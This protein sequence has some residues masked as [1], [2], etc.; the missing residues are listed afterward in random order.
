MFFASDPGLPF[1]NVIEAMQLY[2]DWKMV[3]IATS[4]NLIE[5]PASAGNPVF[6]ELFEYYEFSRGTEYGGSFQKG[7]SKKTN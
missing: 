2:P 4:E 6:S 5:V 3:I 7:S 1:N